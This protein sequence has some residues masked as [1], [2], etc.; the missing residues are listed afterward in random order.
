MIRRKSKRPGAD[1]NQ[2]APANPVSATGAPPPGSVPPGGDQAPPVVIDEL[3][4]AFSNGE[5]P[6]TPPSGRSRNAELNQRSF[7]F[8]RRRR[9]T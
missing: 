7:V 2:V 3:M 6:A 5:V 9:S 4:A 1:G 8:G